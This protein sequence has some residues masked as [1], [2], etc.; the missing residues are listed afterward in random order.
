MV[1]LKRAGFFF[2]FPAFQNLRPRPRPLPLTGG[3]RQPALTCGSSNPRLC[4]KLLCCC[5]GGQHHWGG[6]TSLLGC[7]ACCSGCCFSSFLFLLAAEASTFC[8]KSWA[9]FSLFFS[10]SFSNCCLAAC[11]S[12]AG[13]S[14]SSLLRAE[15]STSSISASQDGMTLSRRSSLKRVTYSKS[16]AL[17]MFP[18]SAL[19]LTENLHPGARWGSLRS[20]RS[21]EAIG[22]WPLTIQTRLT[23]LQRRPVT[24]IWAPPH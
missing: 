21:S 10:I 18:T 16:C 23:V 8:F 4:F 5:W 1:P 9:L 24:R 2:G 19:A 15:P 13:H 22:V 3:S 12:S 14:G 17:N 7:F 6:G 20:N 11:S